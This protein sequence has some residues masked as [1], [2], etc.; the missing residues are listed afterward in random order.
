MAKAKTASLSLSAPKAHGGPAAAHATSPEPRSFQKAST[1]E[2][3]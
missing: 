3:S 1:S 2:R